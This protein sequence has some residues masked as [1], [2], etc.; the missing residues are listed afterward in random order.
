MSMVNRWW[1][2]NPNGHVWRKDEDGNVDL[3]F[4]DNE[5]DFHNGPGCIHCGYC[6]CEHCIK[7][8]QLKPC[9]EKN[10]LTTKDSVVK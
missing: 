4:L 2:D 3:Y 7:E 1:I 10:D 6:F 5:E 9:S 8:G